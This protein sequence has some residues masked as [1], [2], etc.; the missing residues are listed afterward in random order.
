MSAFF[1]PSLMIFD[2]GWSFFFF[3]LKIKLQFMFI[4][5]TEAHALKEKKIQE[6]C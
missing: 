5:D 1:P 3:K 4:R 6:G 2:G